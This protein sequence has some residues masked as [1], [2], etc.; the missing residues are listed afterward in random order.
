MG[1]FIQGDI[2]LTYL[3]L[4]KN[5]QHLQKKYSFLNP[6]EVIAVKADTPLLI[7][8]LLIFALRQE[9]ILFILPPLPLVERA[10]RLQE[11]KCVHFFE[12]FI[13]LKYS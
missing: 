5:V 7:C 13:V 8:A 11:V 6:L 12:I 3:Q 4:E 9:L 10:Q 1:I 2:S